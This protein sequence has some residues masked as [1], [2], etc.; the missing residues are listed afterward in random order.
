MSSRN[1]VVRSLHDLGAAAWFGG[2]LMGAVGVNGAAAAVHDSQDRVRT[3][4]IGWAKWAPVSAVAIGAHL[5]GGA[6]I[7]YANRGRARHQSGVTANTAIKA[8]L[9]GAALGAT[10]YS[11]ILGAR[12]AKGSEV[13]A[14]GATDPSA[15]TPDDVAGAQRQLRYLQWALPAL[16]GTLVILGA[17]QGEQQRP[18]QVLAGVG[19]KLARR[20]QA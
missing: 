4:A 14:D 19:D 7:L 6:S 15:S 9:T 20:A 18:T 11:G 5:L 8:G 17:Q 13:S 16:T 1:T 12:T 10:V 2:S 3:A